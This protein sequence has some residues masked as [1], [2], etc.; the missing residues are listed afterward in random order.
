MKNQTTKTV[1]QM[2]K[3][4]SLYG[5]ENPKSAA[6]IAVGAAGIAG[7]A[8]VLNND[9]DK[10]KKP[11]GKVHIAAFAIPVG[12]KEKKSGGYGVLRR[13]GG[14]GV[15]IDA[16]FTDKD[17]RKGKWYGISDHEI[18]HY[19]DGNQIDLHKEEQINSVL[20][21]ELGCQ[22]VYMPKE[23][24]DALYFDAANKLLW[25]LSHGLNDKIHKDASLNSF[26]EVNKL[27]AQGIIADIKAS[28]N[29]DIPLDDAVWV[30]DYHLLSVPKFL[31]EL[32]PDLPVGF[33]YHIPFP[34]LSPNDIEG[35][36]GAEK[37]KHI[38]ENLLEADFIQF[39]T[40][41]DVQNFLN[42]VTNFGIANPEM[43]AE[44]SEK[45]SINP[46]GIPI[47]S[48]IKSF[49]FNHA[50]FMPIETPGIIFEDALG[51]Q[52]DP[53]EYAPSLH[54]MVEIKS[55]EWILDDN[56]K[57]KPET[58]G[59]LTFDPDKIHTASVSRFDY[60]KGIL[61]LL[62]GYKDFLDQK[63]VDGVENPGEKYQLNIVA[64]TPRD[65]KEYI[66]YATEA[67]GKMDE[68][69]KEYPGSFV[70]IPGI[71]N[72]NLAL[73]NGI[74]DVSIAPSIKDGY[75]ISIG[76]AFIARDTALKM[77][78][79]P[80]KNRPS[81]V[82]VSSGAGISRQL[83]KG[84]SIPDLSI[85]EPT[86]DNIKKSL[87]LQTERIEF[88]RQLP[89]SNQ[90]NLSRF[91]EIPKRVSTTAEFGKKALVEFDKVQAAKKNL[92]PIPLSSKTPYP[93]R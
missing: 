28:N 8:G 88:S 76:E 48:V 81:A 42:T 68:L 13:P 66:D 56:G 84:G 65:I 58:K 35:V 83:E 87:L 34:D 19:K 4:V 69:L 22:Y 92:K 25:P 72:N 24:K 73:F 44:I 52:I 38:L 29:G 21:E 89:K 80:I 11:E 15:G 33:F 77:N 31:K 86:I 49:E 18:D 63:R 61:E 43:L 71:P 32:A 67:Q 17:P 57:I 93:G 64:T 26:D 79:L 3:A 70:F 91:S 41:E 7:I 74:I 10:S 16:T 78:T 60:T 20:N 53:N 1:K 40:L 54:R 90:K 14:L 85:I 5:K 9:K 82:I 36:E 59:V 37:F 39:H 30:H 45:I 46:I 51:T 27:F 75:L 12:I 6:G 47:D 50:N 55:Q 2:F 23:I 62:D